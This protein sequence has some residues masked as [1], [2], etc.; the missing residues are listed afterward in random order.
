RLQFRGSSFDPVVNVFALLDRSADGASLEGPNQNISIADIERLERLELLTQEA[1]DCARM[2]NA[3]LEQA[4][5]ADSEIANVKN[6]VDK[7][8]KRAVQKITT[9]L[10]EIPRRK[11]EM[12]ARK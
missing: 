9:I 4:L 10:E 11:L 8:T 1:I 7:N 12:V 3:S 6:T 5:L 2:A